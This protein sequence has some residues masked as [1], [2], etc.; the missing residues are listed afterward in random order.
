MVG[1][2][3]ITLLTALSPR[4]TSHRLEG[5]L[6]GETVHIFQKGAFD[7]GSRVMMTETLDNKQQVRNVKQ[8]FSKN[9]L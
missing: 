8:K 5:I 3:Y 4:A 9:F 6:C 7:W 2:G 1:Q